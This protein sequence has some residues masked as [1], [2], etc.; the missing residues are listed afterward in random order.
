MHLGS[1]GIIYGI[2]HAIDRE[3]LVPINKGVVRGGLPVI[4]IDITVNIDCRMEIRAIKRWPRKDIGNLSSWVRLKRKH[5]RLCSQ[6]GHR[7]L[8]LPDSQTQ[9][10][11]WEIPKRKR[12]LNT[13]NSIL[14]NYQSNLNFN[15]FTEAKYG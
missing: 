4:I 3:D 7:R 14:L 1:D 6:E 2:A 15:F 12:L 8:G 11:N 9:K 5:S 13:L 10:D